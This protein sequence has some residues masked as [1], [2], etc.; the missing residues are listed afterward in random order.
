MNG[1]P[2]KLSVCHDV[3][4]CLQRRNGQINPPVF[5]ITHRDTLLGFRDIL[6]PVDKLLRALQLRTKHLL[7]EH[8][9]GF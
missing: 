9:A 2:L 4:K 7:G 8:A 5:E 1:L 3:Q 6:D